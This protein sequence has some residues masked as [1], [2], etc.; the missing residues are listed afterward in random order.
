MIE[1]N[2]KKWMFILLNIHKNHILKAVFP[3]I[4]IMGFYSFSVFYILDKLEIDLSGSTVIHSLLG[5]VLG[6]LLVFRTNTAYDRWW[7][8]R[9]LWGALVN[10]SRNLAI[11]MSVILDDD[12]LAKKDFA[13][14]IADFAVALKLHLREETSSFERNLNKFSFVQNK[15]HIPNAVANNIFAMIHKLYKSNKISG[16]ELIIVDRHVSAFSDISGACERIRNTPIPY[17]YNFHLKEVIMVYT[18][19]LPWVLCSTLDYWAIPAV[20]VVFYGFIA[21]ELIA[22]QIENPFG[23]DVDDLPLD[24]ICQNIKNNVYEILGCD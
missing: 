17:S 14:Y 2:T 8:G 1:Y 19:T 18:V 21:I 11:K 16:E 23:S 22:E 24:K 12:N 7:E 10:D 6:L 3:I 13:E 5:I 9:R 15:K 20:M 4:I